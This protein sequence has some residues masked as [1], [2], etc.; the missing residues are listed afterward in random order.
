MLISHRIV[1][2]Y[3]VLKRHLSASGVGVLV[4]SERSKAIMKQSV[5]PALWALVSR[6]E[7]VDDDVDD[8][9]SLSALDV[10]ERTKNVLWALVKKKE[11]MHDQTDINH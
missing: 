5:C 3:D 4:L 9:T 7:L 8:V 11:T 10:V 1:A 2:L 6:T